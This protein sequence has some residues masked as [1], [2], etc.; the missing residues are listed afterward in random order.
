M[1]KY[2]DFKVI[3]EEFRVNILQAFEI[4]PKSYVGAPVVNTGWIKTC[5]ETQKVKCTQFFF[6]LIKNV[7]ILL[8]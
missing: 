2:V 6:M 3:D 7:I 8:A 5:H 4:T 1:K